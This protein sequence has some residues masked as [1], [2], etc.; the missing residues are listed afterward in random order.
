MNNSL[1]TVNILSYNRKAELRYTLTKVFE[2]DYKN[3]EVIVV[4]NA[5]SDGTPGMVKEEFPQVKLIELEKNIGIAGW[6]KGFEIAKGEFVLV[7]D[8][9]SYPENGTIE[10]GVKVIT[11]DDKN[12]VVGF[13]IYNSY[14]NLIENIEEYNNSNGKV[15]ETLGFIGCGA[16][17]R[18]NIFNKLGGFEKAIFLYYNE[19]EFSIRA[20]DK[21][22]KILYLPEYKVIHTYSLTQR[23]EKAG[24]KIFIN[25]R[26]FEHTF[27]SY[28]LFQFLHFDAKW[29]VKYS[30][31]LILS[32]FYIA[33]KLGF[34]KTF[35]KTL[36]S[37]PFLL[38][39]V[40]GKR[41]PARKEVQRLYNYGNLKFKDLYVYYTN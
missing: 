14:F 27:K 35:F 7:L 30:V 24:T 41:V 32:K 19:L 16:I 11:D 10:A 28:M 31:K 5:S 29:F 33:L 40:R 6:N 17:I 13:T 39:K 23:N 21:G 25:E 18:K 22:Y 12:A 37:L 20:R 38:R 1:V 9:D 36:F 8:D 15:I 26:R 34:I 2:Q 4:D 3:I